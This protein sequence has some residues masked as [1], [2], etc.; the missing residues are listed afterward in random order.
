MKEMMDSGTTVLF[1]S[2][3]IS[4]I[5][6]FCTRGIWIHNGEI[7][8]DGEVNEVADEYLGFLRFKKE[9]EQ[10]II[11][12]TLFETRRWRGQQLDYRCCYLP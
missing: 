9:K 2:H 4:A 11:S 8:K 5:R 1:V 3:D 7:Q 12:C 10:T 6:R